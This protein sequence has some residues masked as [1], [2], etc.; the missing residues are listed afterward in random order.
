MKIPQRQDQVSLEAP[1]TAAGNVPEPTTAGLGNSYIKTMQGLSKS[2]QDISDLQYKLSMNATEAQIDRFNLYTAER[3]KQYEQELSLA[4]TQEQIQNLFVNYKK[5]IDENGINTLGAELYS[6]WYSREGGQKVATAEYTGSLASA[7]LQIALNKQAV[8]DAGRQY[9]E[10]A[11]TANNPEEREKYV[12]EWEDMLS[13]YVTNGTISESEKQN[14]QREWNLNFTRSLVTQD[15]DLNPEKTAEKLRKDK[16]YAPIL[17]G[18][19]RLRLANDAMELAAKRKNTGK[20][21]TVELGAEVWRSL[22][23]SENEET[24]KND[25]E[26]ASK[27]YDIFANHQE[28]AKKILAKWLGKDEKEVSY[29]NVEDVL[30][31]MNATLDRENQDRQFEFMENLDTIKQNQNLLFQV[32]EMDE[33]DKNKVKSI[34]VPSGEKLYNAFLEGKLKDTLSNPGQLTSLFKSYQNL[35]DTKEA[36]YYSKKNKKSYEDIF[37]RQQDIAT[38]YVKGI[39]SDK[40]VLEDE[41]GEPWQSQ[42]RGS[43]QSVFN[44]IDKTGAGTK[45]LQESNMARFTSELWQIME[46]EKL[47][48]PNANFT[49]DE[50]KKIVSA[51][52]FAFVKSG[53]PSDYAILFFNATPA[54]KN[55]GTVR[56][57]LDGFRKS[58][59]VELEPFV[60][61]SSGRY[62]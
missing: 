20:D 42:M 3:T 27:I 12:K 61:F 35:T 51:I 49:E 14:V 52:E 18:E 8:A 38:L 31:K 11:F 41:E 28:Q 40:E 13:R 37:K 48:D 44:A 39:R 32:K 62:Y 15:M 17:T 9:N 21:R 33:K 30:A 34:Y 50:T 60:P 36:K 59:P 26:Q 56:K 10:L 29:E 53:L 58:K 55:Q 47:F 54:V 4:T 24:G 5:D 1:R 23:W 22:Y 43:F 19:E 45:E 57:I 7:Q 6:G 16:D 2:L 25:R 46:P